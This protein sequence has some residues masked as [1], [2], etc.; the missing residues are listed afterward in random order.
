MRMRKRSINFMDDWPQL[1]VCYMYVY[2]NAMP[3]AGTLRLFETRLVLTS[4]P[5][6]P[7]ASKQDQCLFRGG[8]Y[9]IVRN[10]GGN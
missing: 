5:G 10:I 6:E 8:F 7:L 4:E 2:C 1:F 9:R 3:T